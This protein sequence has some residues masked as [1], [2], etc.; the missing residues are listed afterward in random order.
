MQIQYMIFQNSQIDLSLL[1]SIDDIHYQRLAPAH[2][3]VKY[4]SNTIFFLV[5]LAGIIYL[6]FEPVVSEHPRLNNG[7]LIFWFVWLLI[8]FILTK[9]NY[10][11]E[12]YALR[13]K[14]IVHIK[15]VI[16]RKQVAV[17]FNR[18]QHCEIKAGPIQRYFNLKTLEIYTAGGHSSDLSIAGLKGE[19]AQVLKDFII[20][21]TGQV[22]NDEE[23]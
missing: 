21:T 23:E 12:G 20:K 16:N 17:P 5:M 8:S 10:D 6:R 14:D 18:V 15:G 1:P 13:E 9:M 2:V 7:L 4:I 3:K 11:I 19:D 22:S